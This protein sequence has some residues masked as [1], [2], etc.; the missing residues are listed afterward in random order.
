M[1]VP[2]ILTRRLELVS[3]SP[4]FLRAVLDDQQ[5]SAAAQ[6]GA[7]LPTSWPDRATWSFQLRLDQLATEPE[8]QPWL[9]RGMVERTPARRFAGYINFHAPPDENGMAEIGY[10]VLPEH[11]RLGYAEEGASAMFAWAAQQGVSTI[12]ASISPTNAPSL[13]LAAKLGFVRTG[14]Q[15]DE[16]D[17]EEL[18]FERP[19]RL[20]AGAGR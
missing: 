5:Q 10:T 19:A 7:R 9:L 6:I 13:S 3:L 4:A 16:E 15:W 14:R 8:Q 12:R 11:R 17:G 1:H 18:V 2:S 20:P